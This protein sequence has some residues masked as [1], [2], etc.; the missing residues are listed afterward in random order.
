M[1]S[2]L[3]NI[4]IVLSDGA[5]NVNVTYDRYGK[6]IYGDDLLKT[7]GEKRKITKIK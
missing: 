3:P 1:V 7:G 6:L 4:A 2:F 5:F